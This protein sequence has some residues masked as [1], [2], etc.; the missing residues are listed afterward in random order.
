MGRDSSVGIATRYGLD[1][2]R[3]EARSGWYLSHPCTSS[4]GPTQPPTMGT[5][6]YRG[7]KRPGR[8]VGHPP[9]SSAEVKETVELYLYSP[10][11]FVSCSRVNVT[12]TFTQQGRRTC[13]EGAKFEHI[14]WKFAAMRTF[15]VSWKHKV[16]SCIK[17][18]VI[19][20]NV[21]K[22]HSKTCI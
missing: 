6:S 17:L 7:V 14:W 13:S 4:L 21:C 22:K 10:W 9:P 19:N 11:A 5:G 3:I 12:F 18:Q 8:G 20:A 16:I 1:G 2:L 15:V